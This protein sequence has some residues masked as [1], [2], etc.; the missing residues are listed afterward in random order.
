MS[1]LTTSYHESLVNALRDP[2][3]AAEYLTA[4][5][6]D[7][8][9]AVLLIALQNVAEARGLHPLPDTLPTLPAL[10][11]L[12]ARLGLEVTIGVKAA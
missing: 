4:A 8:D 10:V 9:P 11:A 5:L 1:Q 7:G 6:E 2:G 12:L 3:E